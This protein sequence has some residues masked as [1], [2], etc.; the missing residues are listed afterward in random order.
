MGD[1][2]FALTSRKPFNLKA[3]LKKPLRQFCFAPFPCTIGEQ[4]MSNAFHFF[5]LHTLASYWYE[6]LFTVTVTN[7]WLPPHIKLSDCSGKSHPM[8]TK[9]K[10]KQLPEWNDPDLPP[11]DV[12]ESTHERDGGVRQVL[13]HRPPGSCSLQQLPQRGECEA[14]GCCSPCRVRKPDGGRTPGWC[15][16][17]TGAVT[18]QRSAS[19]THL[20]RR[21]RPLPKTLQTDRG[22]LLGLTGKPKS[23]RRLWAPQQCLSASSEGVMLSVLHVVRPLPHAKFQCYWLHRLH[24]NQRETSVRHWS[25]IQTSQPGHLCGGKGDFFKRDADSAVSTTVTWAVPRADGRSGP[26]LQ[27]QPQLWPVSETPVDTSPLW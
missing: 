27:S 9:M 1:D 3:L 10:Q 19:G 11:L 20:P 22:R 16:A 5:P 14:R 15:G 17:H 23:K 18:P 21:A 26:R 7:K 4:D 8:I 13:Q 12:S 6:Y 24:A 2:K 25:F